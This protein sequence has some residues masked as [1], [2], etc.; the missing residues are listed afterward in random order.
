MVNMNNLYKRFRN[1]HRVPNLEATSLD[2]I[3]HSHRNAG[4]LVT[5]AKCAG[6]GEVNMCEGNMKTFFEKFFV[7]YFNLFY[8]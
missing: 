7:L 1:G 5:Q 6:S 8:I 3:V 2:E 4:F